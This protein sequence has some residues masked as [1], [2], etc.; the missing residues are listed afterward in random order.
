MKKLLLLSCM[1]LSACQ[2]EAVMLAPEYKVVKA[3]E[4]L[5]NCPIKKAFP[6]SETLTDKQVGSVIL[7][8]QK[9]NI[10]CK[11]SLDSIK[12]FYDEAEKK[13]EKN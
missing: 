8:L 2:T 3:P 6:S 9:N 11:N 5:Y 7:D 1:F 13:I 12:K 10:T 4:K